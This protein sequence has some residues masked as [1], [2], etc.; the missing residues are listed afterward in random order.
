VLPVYLVSRTLLTLLTLAL[1][2][3][4]RH[5]PFD[6]WMVLDARWYV[7]IAVHGYGWSLDGKPALAFFPL[8]PFLI[9]MSV[10]SGMAG[11]VGAM[12]VS[13]CAMSA[14]LLYIRGLFLEEWGEAVARRAIWL[15]AFFPT[16]F[17]TFAPYSESLFLLCAA[18]A[19][20]DMERAHLGRAALWVAAAILT[21]STGVALLAPLLMCVA[22]T[23]RR[24]FVLAIGPTV[25]AVGA[26]IGYLLVHHLPVGQLVAAQRHWHRSIAPPWIGFV[27]SGQYL[28]HHFG[29]NAGWT[30]ENLLQ[31]A[32]T[33]LCLGATVAAWRYLTPFAAMYCLGFWLIVLCTPEWRDGF[34]APFSSVDRF[35]LALFPLAAWV[36]GT[37]SHRQWTVGIVGSAALMLGATAVHLSGGWVG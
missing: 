35:A 11:V 31:V 12:I 32:A 28:F 27:A 16:A 5:S 14:A 15:V 9:H 10:Q 23:G 7:G 17:F 36:A 4:R 26:Y 22:C 21:R 13:N 34:F 3:T 25:V 8:Y 30:A 19:L 6:L 24:R 37:L 2:L 20:Y 1:A 33:V 18:A 29:Y